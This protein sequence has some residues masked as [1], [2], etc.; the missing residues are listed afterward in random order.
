MTLIVNGARPRFETIAT[1][2]HLGERRAIL[3]FKRLVEH[4]SGVRGYDPSSAM[5]RYRWPELA[6]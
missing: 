5:L 1:T 4:C 2:M 3:A 6:G